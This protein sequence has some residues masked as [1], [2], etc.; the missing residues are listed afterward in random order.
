MTSSP[1]APPSSIAI[2][3][4]VAT[5]GIATFSAMDALMKGLTLE[6]GAFN[7]MLWRCIIGTGL[8]GLYYFFRRNARPTRAALKLHLIRGCAASFMAVLFFWGIARVPLAEGIAISFIAPLIALYLAALTLQEKIEKRAL[9]ASVLGFI[10]VLVIVYGRSRSDMTRDS[11][12]GVG[13]ILI[14]AVLY[15]YNIVLMRAQAQ[16]AAPP[17]V[18]FFQ[19]LI[20]M[21]C[22]GTVAPFLAVVP[23]TIH[24][25]PLIG[26]AVLATFSLVVLSWAYGRVETQFLLP[27]EYTAFIWA[28][29]FGYVMFNEQVTLTTLAGAAL[30]VAGCILA[31]WRK[32]AAASPLEGLG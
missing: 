15:A 8:S 31:T 2:P 16:A 14:S 4:I 9:V 7:A 22:L 19:N 27:V 26:S 32:K 21:C 10:G 12:L 28:A 13:A 11:L 18:A 23:Q 25:V 3:F 1:A 20:V 29:L 24:I 30:I 5:I 6:I 17:E